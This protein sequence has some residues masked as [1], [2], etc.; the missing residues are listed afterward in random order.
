MEAR[1]PSPAHA[2][3]GSTPGARQR[4]HIAVGQPLQPKRIVTWPDRECTGP[5]VGDGA[6]ESRAPQR[7][8]RNRARHSPRQ[9]DVTDRRATEPRTQLAPGAVELVL[10]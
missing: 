9:A 3:N 6:V 10:D 2:Q 7:R 8:G 1:S 5:A 4:E